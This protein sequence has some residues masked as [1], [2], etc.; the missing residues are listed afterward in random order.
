MQLPVTKGH[1]S[2]NDILVIPVPL[3]EVFNTLDEAATACRRL[4]DRSGPWG[5]DGVYFV[6]LKSQPIDVT[7]RELGRHDRRAMWER[8]EAAGPTRVRSLQY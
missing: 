1:G 8:N 4:C 5:A 3:F 7:F 2:S 6:D